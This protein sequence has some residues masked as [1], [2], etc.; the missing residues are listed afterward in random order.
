M[1]LHPAES[2]AKAIREEQSGVK[3]CPAELAEPLKTSKAGYNI[4]TQ[5]ATQTILNYFEGLYHVF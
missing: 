2:Q 5:D 4:M 1:Q 3:C